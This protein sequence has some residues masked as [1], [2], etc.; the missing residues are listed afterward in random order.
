MRLI[1][2]APLALLAGCQVT[3]GNNSVTVGYNQDVAEN[4]V[5]DIKNGAEEA[6]SAIVTGSKEAGAAVANGA[7]V[8]KDKV[9][10]TDVDVTVTNTSAN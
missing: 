2:L 8:A 9:E 4:A 1:A 6:G 10:N 5:A 3:E 7:E